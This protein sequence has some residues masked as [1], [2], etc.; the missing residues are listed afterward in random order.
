MYAIRSYYETRFFAAT[1]RSQG[2]LVY[3]QVSDWLENGVAEGFMPSDVVANQLNLLHAA[4]TKR[5]QW[6]AEHAILFKDRPD[7]DFELNE[8]GEVVAIHA[9]FRRSANKIVE[10]SMI[11][12]NQFV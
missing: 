1:I 11:A 8:A 12:A 5:Q 6:R 3:D 4:T 9:S 7:Y 2:R 10:E